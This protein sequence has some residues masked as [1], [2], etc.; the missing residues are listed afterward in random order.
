M[1]FRYWLQRDPCR[2]MCIGKERSVP[3]YPICNW[4][5]E[6]RCRNLA[7]MNSASQILRYLWPQSMSQVSNFLHMWLV[8]FCCSLGLM[9]MYV[10][11]ICNKWYI[12]LNLCISK[13]IH[14]YINIHIY[15]YIYIY[16]FT[17]NLYIHIFVYIYIICI[18]TYIYI[19][20]FR[21]IYLLI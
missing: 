13:Y 9:D 6:T 2:V 10:N 1:N 21:I 5:Q 3:A 16:I 7:W 19:Y 18:Y 12:W 20:I 14:T 4:I 8:I 11:R 17:Y 15:V